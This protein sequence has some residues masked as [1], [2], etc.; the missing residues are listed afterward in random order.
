MYLPDQESYLLQAGPGLYPSVWYT[1][2]SGE[3]TVREGILGEWNT[4]G[5]EG[6]W[7]VQLTAVLEGGKILTVAIPLTLDNTPPSIRWIQPSAPKKVSVDGDQP[8]ILQVEVTD[9][10]EVERVDFYLDGK[11]NTR[12]ETGPFSVRWN[13]LA[14]GRHSAKIC[15]KDR[16]GNETC[17]QE[18]AIEVGLK[19]SG[20]LLYNTPGEVEI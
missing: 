18:I 10:L 2:G 3:K 6:V 1:L 17:T 19:T 8:V 12:L 4:A 5:S 7:S 13:A 15:A 20:G 14:P 16:A 11:I 9:N